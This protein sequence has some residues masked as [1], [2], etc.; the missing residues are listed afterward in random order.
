MAKGQGKNATQKG[1]DDF[2]VIIDYY[3]KARTWCNNKKEVEK[4]EEEAFEMEVQK[5][6][7]QEKEKTR[8]AKTPSPKLLNPQPK[9]LD[10]QL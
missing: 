1:R 6:V 8:K 9:P 7:L 2:N 4:L 3:Q 5:R 10:P